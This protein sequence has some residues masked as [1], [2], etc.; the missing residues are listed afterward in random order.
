MEKLMNLTE[1]QVRKLAETLAKEHSKSDL[2]IGLIGPLGAGKTTFV[3]N[4]TK[5]LKIKGVKS[6]TFIIGNVY[7]YSKRNLYHFDFYRLADEKQLS[8][9][10]FDE[11]LGAKNRIMIIEWVD[12][13]PKIQKLCDM[14]I[15]FEVAGRNLRHVTIS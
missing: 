8:V 1:T 7:P 4:F 9:L 14:I 12:K 10:G 5:T 15:N 13:F 6:P 2:I 3:K 11:I